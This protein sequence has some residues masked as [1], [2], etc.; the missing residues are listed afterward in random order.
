[1]PLVFNGAQQG[2]VGIDQRRRC[3]Q[4]EQLR[5]YPGDL[6]R[7]YPGR[8]FNARTVIGNGLGAAGKALKT[9]AVGHPGSE[10]GT[11]RVDPDFS[12]RSAHARLRKTLADTCGVQLQR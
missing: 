12:Q 6:P 10:Q 7:T 9:F 11:D 4:G 8:I 3:A 2:R 5:Q 1:M